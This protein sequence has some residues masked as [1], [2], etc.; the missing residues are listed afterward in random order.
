MR[1]V[2]ERSTLNLLHSA[3][4]SECWSDLLRSGKS[5]HNPHPG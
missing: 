1:K 2:V 4:H 3:W 5:Q